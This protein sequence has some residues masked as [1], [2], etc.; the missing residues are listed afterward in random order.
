MAINP[1]ILPTKQSNIA[2]LSAFLW[3]LNS[4]WKNMC[5]KFEQRYNDAE[6]KFMLDNNNEAMVITDP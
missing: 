4:M 2:Q 1:L 5:K 3:A 6:F